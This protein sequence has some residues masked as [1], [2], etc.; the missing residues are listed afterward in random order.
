[1]VS[2]SPQKQHRS[3]RYLEL[4][5]LREKYVEYDP[6]GAVR[7]MKDTASLKFDESVEAHFRLNIDPKYTDQQLRATVREKQ[8]EAT[9][10]G[11][12]FVGG[13][14]LIEK[15]AGG[16]MDFDKLIATPDMMPKAINEFKAGKVEYRADKTGIVHV[17]F[18]KASFS[19]EDLLENLAAVVSSVDSNRP[20]G[21]KGIYWKTAYVCST[22]GPSIRLNVTQLRE[23]KV[24]QPSA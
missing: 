11:A 1:M 17:L 23:Y 4:Q 19:A 5:K 15:I 13:E 3:K 6:S 2:H 22:M 20:T 9:S 21:S 7:I 12:D 18:G 8:M 16:F 10:A 24:E 14:D